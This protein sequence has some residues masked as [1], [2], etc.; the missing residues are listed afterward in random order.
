MILFGEAISDGIVVG[1][2]EGEGASGMQIERSN[3]V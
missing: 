3:F 2:E 1:G